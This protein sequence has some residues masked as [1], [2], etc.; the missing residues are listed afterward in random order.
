[1]VVDNW[2]KQDYT[3]IQICSCF[4][5][6]N[7]TP[8]W[9][10]QLSLILRSPAVPQ[11]AWEG[12]NSR[13]IETPI[14]ALYIYAVNIVQATSMLKP[15][16]S[17]Y[18]SCLPDQGKSSKLTLLFLPLPVIQSSWKSELIAGTQFMEHSWA[19]VALQLSRD[20]SFQIF[21]SANSQIPAHW[22]FFHHRCLVHP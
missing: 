3:L 19:L 1:M 14:G 20:T 7:V 8:L 12:L 15:A 6:R 9:Q 4:A 21:P 5:D 18:L 17:C 13:I 2:R 10:W 11:E 22:I 16:K